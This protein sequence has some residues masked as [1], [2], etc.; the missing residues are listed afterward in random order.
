M[1]NKIAELTDKIYKE[2]V[3]KGEEQAKQIVES[4]KAKAE[5]IIADAKKEA[6]KIVAD[7]KSQ[8]EEQKR[9]AA[10]EIKLA[11]QQALSSIKQ[12]IL[13][14]VV[15]DAIEKGVSATLDDPAVMKDLIVAVVQSWQGGA[16]RDLSLEVLL[17]EAK[18]EE[19]EKSLA[20]GLQKSLKQGV[21]IS[22]SRGI[23]GGFQIG[24][25]DGSFKVSLTDEDF[26][27]FFK[28][29]LRPK[30]RSYL[31]GQSQ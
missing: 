7:A 4:A 18:K 27:E 24:Q 5:G 19:L 9:N 21:K 13:D 11:G 22:F 1:A 14:V 29:F 2:G 31:F 10:N 23:R 17:P 8:A 28:E 12:Q 25:A 3:E 30:A 16:G 26:A 15:A 20:G 6:E